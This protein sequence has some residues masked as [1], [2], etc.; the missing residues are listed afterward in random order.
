MSP[1]VVP[2]PFDP[3][4]PGS[5]TVL[6]LLGLRMGGLVLVA[7]FFSAKPIPATLKTALVVL[8][9][10]LLQPVALASAHPG[11]QITMETAFGETMIGFAIGLGAALIV[12]AAESAGEL[13]AIQIGLSGASLL[14]PMSNQRGPALGQFVSFFA[15]TLMLALDAH[16]V[17]LDAIAR[18]T[19]VMPIGASLDLAGGARAMVGVGTQLFALGLRFAAPVIAV[20]LIANVSLAIL[21]RAA[22]QLNILSVAFPIQIGVGLLTF[23]ATIPVIA[24]F[25]NGWTGTYESILT[26][27]L[28]ALSGGRAN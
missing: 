4:A 10:I 17:M 13:M 9:S 12:G 18:S 19:R 20:V 21:S 2:A 24:M 15:I 28:G 7:P 3:F 25:F 14:D 22:P 1:D 5:L 26:H 27:S 11:V 16:F 23:A 8:F 6:A